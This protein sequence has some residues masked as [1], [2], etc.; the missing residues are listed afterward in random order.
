[1]RIG[2]LLALGT[3]AGC[4][5]SGWTQSAQDAA[6]QAQQTVTETIETVQT[7]VQEQTGQAGGAEFKLEAEATADSTGSTPPTVAAPTNEKSTACYVLFTLQQD[8]RSNVLALQS[9][10]HAERET[11]PSFYIH[12]QVEAATLA[13]LAG[14]TVP[15]QMYLKS[16]ESGPTLFTPSDAPLQ[17]KIVAVEE[18]RVTAE[19]V[20]GKLLSSTDSVTRDIS[21]QFTAVVP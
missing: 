18:T 11:F 7:E 3:L 4:D 20:G 6:Q 14:Q 1:M 16:R 21:G 10:K 13:E 19:I 12:A 9:Y 8:G 2:F 15:A 17:L 5:F